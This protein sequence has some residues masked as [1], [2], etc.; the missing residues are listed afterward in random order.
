MKHC[1]TCSADLKP[2]D[3]KD[4]RAVSLLGREFCDTCVERA[5]EL[6]RPGAESSAGAHQKRGETH[7]PRPGSANDPFER[8]EEELE[9]LR[10]RT[11]DRKA[12]PW[13]CNLYLRKSGIRGI[14]GGNAVRLW[15][16]VSVR[17]G[18]A[19]LEGTFNVGD[20]IS[21]WIVL[22]PMGVISIVRERARVQEVAHFHRNVL[23]S[24]PRLQRV[25]YLPTIDRYVAVMTDRCPSCDSKVREQLIMFLG[26]RTYRLRCQRCNRPFEVTIGD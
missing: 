12:P 5:A 18:R 8:T 21:L 2:A 16:D 17:G 7:V 3:F 1:Y 24:D 14:F 26:R 22:T 15:L 25:S 13:G 6:S 11:S 10:R 9:E 23:L 4:G 19:I 20:E